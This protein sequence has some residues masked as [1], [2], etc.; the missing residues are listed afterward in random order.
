[1]ALVRRGGKTYLYRSVRRSGR[2]TSEYMASGAAA[3]LIE[4][5]ARLDRIVNAGLRALPPMDPE[6]RGRLDELD[7]T[8]DVLVADARGMAHDALAAAGYH[9]HKRGEWRRRRVERT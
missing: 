4:A 7:R 2:V 5:Q 6:E 8:L 3:E 9:Q 1:M